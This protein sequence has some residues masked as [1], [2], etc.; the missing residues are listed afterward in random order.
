M[1]DQIDYK[2]YSIKVECINRYFWQAEVVNSQIHLVGG[3]CARTRQDAIAKAQ[4][5][6]NSWLDHEARQS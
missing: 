2:G 5:L 6:V 3:V 4:N 1:L